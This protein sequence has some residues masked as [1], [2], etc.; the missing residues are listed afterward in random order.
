M[1][2]LGCMQ[3][4]LLMMVVAFLCAVADGY[5]VGE[6]NRSSKGRRSF[7][8]APFL[9]TAAV[10]AGQE[11]AFALDMDAFMQKELSAPCNELTDK[12]CRPNLSDDA[13]LCRFGQPSK[14][15]G[16]ACLRAGMS[17]A[18]NATPRSR[19]RPASEA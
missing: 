11:K 13:A 1:M 3:V 6:A 10:A 12:K 17:T 5:S 9:A 16:D 19:N 14:D 18:R 8:A 2:V 7:L 4:A 15:T